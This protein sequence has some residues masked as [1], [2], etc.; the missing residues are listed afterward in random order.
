MEASHSHS[1]ELLDPEI[2]RSNLTN[3]TR[4]GYNPLMSFSSPPLANPLWGNVGAVRSPFSSVGSMR[5]S[6]SMANASHDLPPAHDHMMNGH[7]HADMNCMKD[8]CSCSHAHTER[9]KVYEEKMDKNRLEHIMFS[10]CCD[11]DP[12]QSHKERLRRK[13]RNKQMKQKKQEKSKT[14]V[15]SSDCNASQKTLQNLLQDINGKSKHKNG[16]QKG[17]KKKKQIAQREAASETANKQMKQKKQE[18]SKTSVQSSDCNASQ[19]TLQNLLQDINGKSKHKNGHQKGNKKKKHKTQHTQHKEALTAE[20]HQQSQSKP[21]KKNGKKRNHRRKKT[22]PA[23]SAKSSNPG[24]DFKS[25][26]L[27]ESVNESESAYSTKQESVIMNEMKEHIE[28]SASSKSPLHTFQESA[29]LLGGKHDV[30]DVK[31]NEIENVSI[32]QDERDGRDKSVSCK[33]ASA[34]PPIS[35]DRL[36]DKHDINGHNEFEHVQTKEDEHE[37]EDERESVSC[38]SASAIPPISIDRLNDKHDINGHNEHIQTKEDEHEHEHEDEDEDEHNDVDES[39]LSVVKRQ[40]E[41]IHALQENVRMLSEMIVAMQE[42]MNEEK[43]DK[44]QIR[45]EIVCLKQRMNIME[46]ERTDR[47]ELRCWLENEVKLEQYYEVLVDNGFEDKLSVSKINE[48]MLVE[49]G[50]CKMGHQQ[51]IL[52]FVE[53]LKDNN[54]I[55]H[56]Y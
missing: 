56:Q 13:L 45:K 11:H 3:I 22:S 23:L 27:C 42:R 10:G 26:D 29:D 40:N 33:S 34:I 15:Q 51:K 36:N 7:N 5:P 32:F 12:L 50:I 21:S 52:H 38:K 6:L 54:M 20:N 14:S 18:K 46:N 8:S 47:E 39:L 4:A 25:H 41:E 2:I 19:K 16:H 49:M 17:N 53:L 43:M 37:D 44:K 9:A 30:D 28:D 35:I 31:E 24:T 55:P 48:Q 1:D